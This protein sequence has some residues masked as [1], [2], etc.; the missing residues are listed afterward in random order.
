M[1]K[2]IFKGVCLILLLVLFDFAAGRFFSFLHRLA[3]G[4][5]PYGLVT[6]YAMFKVD[7]EVI[8]I[9]SSRAVHHYVPEIL[10]D[11]LV[12]SVHNCG[13]DGA[14]LLYQ[15]CLIDGILNRIKPK[16]VIWDIEPTC[17]AEGTSADYL[18]SDLNPFYD[19][20][21]FCQQV[22]DQSKPAERY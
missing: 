14:F 5:S 1:K 2:Y 21:K 9:G 20:N 13:K 7:T 8:I 6:E 12:M 22:I 11:S 16:L 3:F 17:F 18:L 19:Q 4:K 10:S 15:C